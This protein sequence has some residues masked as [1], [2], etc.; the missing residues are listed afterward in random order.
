M[1]M[2]CVKLNASSE[3][4]MLIHGLSAYGDSRLVGMKKID[5][6][7][8]LHKLFETT[9]GDDTDTMRTPYHG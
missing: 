8:E 9:P 1:V 7:L 3:I 5:F 4:T 6:Q 2:R